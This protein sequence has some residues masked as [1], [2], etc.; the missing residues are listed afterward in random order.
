MLVLMWILL[1]MGVL[2]KLMGMVGGLLRGV[3]RGC[4]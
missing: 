2:L 3:G 4:R 1:L